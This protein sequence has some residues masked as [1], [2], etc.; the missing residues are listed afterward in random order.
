MSNVLSLPDTALLQDS[1]FA[2]F[3]RPGE[4]IMTLGLLVSC[5]GCIGGAI[6]CISRNLQV[7]TVKLIYFF[8]PISNSDAEDISRLLTEM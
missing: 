1:G 6:C 4:I 2:A 8:T 7:R 3:G 5:L